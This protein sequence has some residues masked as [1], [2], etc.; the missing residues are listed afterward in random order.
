MLSVIQCT[1]I[2]ICAHTHTRVRANKLRRTNG[3]MIIGGKKILDNFTHGRY[4]SV[5]KKRIK[6][7][8][9]DKKFKGYLGRKRLSL[10]LDK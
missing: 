8:R 1:Y 2:H 3:K 9:N 7:K 6:N 5:N 10:R 4:S